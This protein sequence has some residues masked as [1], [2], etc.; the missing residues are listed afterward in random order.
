MCE[1]T[2]PDMDGIM[3]AFNERNKKSAPE[4][5]EIK[6][7]KLALEKFTSQKIRGNEYFA[8]TETGECFRSVNKDDQNEW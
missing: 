3:A 6:E 7:L 5:T 1:T 8:L 2:R 4:E